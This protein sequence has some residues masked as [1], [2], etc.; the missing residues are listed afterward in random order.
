MS[1]RDCSQLPQ[2]GASGRRLDSWVAIV[3]ASAQIVHTRRCGFYGSR[4]ITVFSE[5]ISSRAKC[6]AYVATIPPK[7][8]P[9]IT[10][11]TK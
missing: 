2:P 10:S 7:T 6:T 11:L 5:G 8:L 9:A 3:L 1:Q 4:A